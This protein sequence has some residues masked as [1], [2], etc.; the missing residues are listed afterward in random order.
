MNISNTLNN[1]DISTLNLPN[2]DQSSIEEN[3]GQ[4]FN[5][6]F[7][8]LDKYETEYIKLS[9]V[10]KPESRTLI[11]LKAKIDILR[12]SLKR[13]NEI[14]TKYRELRLIAL[15]DERNLSSISGKLDSYKI[16]QALQPLPW[17]LISKPSINEDKIFPNFPFF[18]TINLIG[19][20]LINTS[21]L[22]VKK[23][24][25]TK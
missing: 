15:R 11:D 13:P 25:K 14:L 12:E 4:R 22:T 20:I 5:G 2:S 6:Q 23:I 21:Y 16:E 17:D 18:L 1:L 3:S 19:I 7:K 9:S 24:L 8:L 10:L